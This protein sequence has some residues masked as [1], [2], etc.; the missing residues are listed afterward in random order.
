MTH[1]NVA[2]KFIYRNFLSCENSPHS[3]YK[4]SRYDLE[5]KS[6]RGFFC[7][8]PCKSNYRLSDDKSFCEK[9]P[10][11][12]PYYCPQPLLFRHFRK[13]KVYGKN[14]IQE[15]TPQSHPILLL[16]SNAAQ[17]EYINNFNKN[18]KEYYNTCQDINSPYYKIIMLLENT[19]A[20]GFAKN[21]NKVGDEDENIKDDI[22]RICKQTYCENENY[23]NLQ[24]MKKM[25][26]NE[27]IIKDNNKFTKY[28]KILILGIILYSLC[29]YLVNSFNS[30]I[31]N[32]K[33]DN[34]F[35][36]LGG[37]DNF[38]IKSKLVFID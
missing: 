30:I 27:E 13:E 4:N 12:V 38:K 23:E 19:C 8:K 17:R 28:L 32:K 35:T 36:W 20:Y 26:L 5:N 3:W 9:A 16:N 24:N 29:I 31:N 33:V 7:N 15:F 22:N 1:I 25:P 21:H 14:F 37:H 18:K 2:S 10:T 34:P 6:S 11:N